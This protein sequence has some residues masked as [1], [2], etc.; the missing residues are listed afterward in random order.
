ME[1]LGNILRKYLKEIGVEKPVKRYEALSLWGSVVGKRISDV[2][3]PV[4]I[5]DGKIFIKVKS[6]PWRNELLYHKQR[7]IN[8]INQRLES[9]MITDIVLI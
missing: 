3:E 6:D 1:L 4:R 7:I 5:A 8:D 2:T 9:K